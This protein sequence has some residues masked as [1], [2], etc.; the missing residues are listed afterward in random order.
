M[1]ARGNYVLRAGEGA[2]FQNGLADRLVGKEL[3]MWTVTA[4]EEVSPQEILITLE[5]DVPFNSGLL[6]QYRIGIANGSGVYR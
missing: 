6:D 4:A 5:G 1:K 2:I 3:G